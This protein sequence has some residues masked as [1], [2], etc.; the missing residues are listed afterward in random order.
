MCNSFD[1]L[2]ERNI[3]F[4]F[5]CYK[6]SVIQATIST[7]LVLGMLHFSEV[8]CLRRCFWMTV[9][10]SLILCICK[11]KSIIITQ[12]RV[13]VALCI[14]MHCEWFHVGVVIYDVSPPRDF[15]VR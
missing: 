13:L 1:S 11:T 14:L 4:H 3:S 9:V 10:I 2:E 12:K 6:E 8:V 5:S 7:Y 15:L